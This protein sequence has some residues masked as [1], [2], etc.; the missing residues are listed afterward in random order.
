MTAKVNLIEPT[1]PR[2]S[3]STGV[4]RSVLYHDGVHERTTVVVD[5]RTIVDATPNNVDASSSKK[6]HAM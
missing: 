1:S 4:S 5:A 3:I 6:A 2:R